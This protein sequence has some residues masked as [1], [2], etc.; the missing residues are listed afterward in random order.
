MRY[1]RNKRR[2]REK[3]KM[4]KNGTR[5]LRGVAEEGE[6]GAR[7]RKGLWEGGRSTSGREEEREKPKGRPLPITALP[8][9]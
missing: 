2:A 3:D 1:T 8:V 5:S 9:T 4:R 7:K 6:Q